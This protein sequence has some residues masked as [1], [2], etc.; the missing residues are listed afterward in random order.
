MPA[1]GTPHP[2]LGVWLIF[3]RFI[4]LAKTWPAKY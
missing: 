1:W 4:Y 2:T 3:L